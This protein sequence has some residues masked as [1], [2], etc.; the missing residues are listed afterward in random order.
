MCAFAIAVMGCIVIKREKKSKKANMTFVKCRTKKSNEFN[1]SFSSP[2]RRFIDFRFSA[3]NH[4]HT[5]IRLK[6]HSCDHD[7]SNKHNVHQLISWNA[8]F[9]LDEDKN[10]KLAKIELKSMFR[11]EINFER[12]HLK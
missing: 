12:S 6:C 10:R 7:G 5:L 3:K 1:R 11:S 8:P 9:E 4:F 2:Y